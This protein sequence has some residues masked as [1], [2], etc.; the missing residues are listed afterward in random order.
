M[1]RY[2]SPFLLPLIVMSLAACSKFEDRI[3]N[4]K[5]PELPTV[6]TYAPEN[7]TS[8][9]A[10]LSGSIESTGGS[11]ITESGIYIYISGCVIT[12]GPCQV[13]GFN[14]WRFSDNNSVGH[15]SVFLRD[16]RPNTT[17]HY[18]AFA[19]NEFGTSFGDMQILI[20]HEGK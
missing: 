10:C 9:T 8:H 6:S 12:P 15:F 11:I 2:S 7:I 1:K 16:L 4:L 19:K 18:R 14:E 13:P 5:F 3:Y 20:T 17:Y